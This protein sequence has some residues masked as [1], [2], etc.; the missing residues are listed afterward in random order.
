MAQPS[1]R[2]PNRKPFNG[3][4]RDNMEYQRITPRERLGKKL[5]LMTSVGVSLLLLVS[6]AAFAQTDLEEA[7]RIALLLGSYPWV[8]FWI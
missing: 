5:R 1:N 4:I 3:K 6:A 2:A 7:S 8:L